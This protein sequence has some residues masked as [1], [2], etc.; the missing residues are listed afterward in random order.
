MGEPVR[1]GARRG[2]VASGVA[3]GA[4]ESLNSLGYI[5]P[6]SLSGVLRNTNALYPYVPFASR[7]RISMSLDYMYYA[8]ALT[9]RLVVVLPL[10]RHEKVHG[11]C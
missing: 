2:D 7:Q 3:S 8:F 10:H 11:T 4:W 9:S 1:G 6:N 5:H